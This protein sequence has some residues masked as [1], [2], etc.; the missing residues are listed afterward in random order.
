[1]DIFALDSS[2]VNRSLESTDNPVVPRPCK[3]MSRK[4]PMNKLPLWQGIFDV[5]ES[6]VNEHTSIVPGT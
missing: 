3:Q 6:R 5:V 4:L 1:M 2:E